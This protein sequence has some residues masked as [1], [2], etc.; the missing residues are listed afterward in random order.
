[1]SHVSSGQF[2]GWGEPLIS[3]LENGRWYTSF[4]AV[5]GISNIT[6]KAPGTCYQ[7]DDRVQGSL[8]LRGQV[9]KQVQN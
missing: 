5:A 4:P 6:G 1:M 8:V 9:L 2:L 3:H 7:L